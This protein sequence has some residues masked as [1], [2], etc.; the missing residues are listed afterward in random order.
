VLRLTLSERGTDVSRGVALDRRELRGLAG[1]DTKGSVGGRRGDIA[2]D[3]FVC[4][5]DIVRSLLS[6][7]H[8][9]RHERRGRIDKNT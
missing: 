3:V 8:N 9:S 4:W 2:G 5:D 1:G 7:I 6:R